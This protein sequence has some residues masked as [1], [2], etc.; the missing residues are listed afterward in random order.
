MT[1]LRY[2]NASESGYR[3]AFVT[4]DVLAELD[5]STL[6]NG[7]YNLELFVRY[8][9]VISSTKTQFILDCP[10]KIGNV[11]FSN[12]PGNNH[13]CHVLVELGSDNVHIRN[14]RGFTSN[15]SDLWLQCGRQ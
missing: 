7:I 15:L 3:K 14:D 1:S 13:I 6:P 11:K 8:K 4:N 2:N 12:N 5:F 10:L 9:G